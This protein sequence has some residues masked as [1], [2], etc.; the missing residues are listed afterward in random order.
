MTKYLG[1]LFLLIVPFMVGC[2]QKARRVATQEEVQKSTA[3][4]ME[5][6]T[7]DPLKAGKGAAKSK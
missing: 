3:N 6:A 2:G 1:L 4:P 5:M 7:P